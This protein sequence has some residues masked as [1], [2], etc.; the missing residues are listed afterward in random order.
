VLHE[1]KFHE[2]RSFST[3]RPL[4]QRDDWRAA[5]VRRNTPCRIMDIRS[6]D[7]W[8]LWS[9]VRNGTSGGHD[10]D[11]VHRKT[12]SL[13]NSNARQTADMP[14]N[15]FSATCIYLFDKFRVA[16]ENGRTRIA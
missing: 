12:M 1:F 16:A 7:T 2:K 8:G 4:F 15:T 14:S 3:K 5:D 10:I 11:I 13:R 9:V 6:R